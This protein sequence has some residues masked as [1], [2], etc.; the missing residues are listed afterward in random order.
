[1]SL[2]VHDYS[3]LQ[4]TWGDGPYQGQPV[5]KVA[6]ESGITLEVVKR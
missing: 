4:K 1:L 6:G 3:S 5:E 2:G